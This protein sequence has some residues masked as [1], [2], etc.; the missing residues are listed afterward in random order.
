[1]KQI[2]R[3]KSVYWVDKQ[4]CRQRSIHW[5]DKQICK[6]R[7]IHRVDRDLYIV[8]IEIWRSVFQ[9]NTQINICI[10]GRQVVIDL[11]IGKISRM[12]IETY[13]SGRQVDKDLYIGQIGIQR[14]VFQEDTQ[15]KICISGRYVECRQKS[16]NKMDR[17]N[18][19][20]DMYIPPPY[21]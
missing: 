2:G 1:M 10:S 3:Q 19:D 17:Q 20:G 7:T 15:I 14:Y 18:V 4:I 11:Y 12:Q 13:S 9:E 8:Q 21:L 16:V 5:V 6:Q